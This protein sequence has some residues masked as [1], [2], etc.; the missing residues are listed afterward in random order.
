MWN[1]KAANSIKVEK[2]SGAPR[3]HG[4]LDFVATIQTVYAPIYVLKI[5][6]KKAETTKS[7]LEQLLRHKSL[8]HRPSY[9]LKLR[10]H[11]SKQ[12]KT[13]KQAT[14][15]GFFSATVLVLL[16]PWVRVKVCL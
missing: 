8:L 16:D 10:A 12:S 2:K 4:P 15:W 14:F 6:R 9:I 5:F 7:M 13:I 3:L 1:T 11:T